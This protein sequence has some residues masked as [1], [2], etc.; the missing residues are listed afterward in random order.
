MP[1]A[2]N[3]LRT[4]LRKYNIPHGVH[5]IFDVEFHSYRIV[6]SMLSAGHGDAG[7]NVRVHTVI[8]VAC[9]NFGIRNFLHERHNSDAEILDYIAVC[10]LYVSRACPCRIAE[11]VLLQEQRKG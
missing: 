3:E 8:V 4:A 9:G 10:D 7:V 2:P 11:V 5:T 6:G 1:F